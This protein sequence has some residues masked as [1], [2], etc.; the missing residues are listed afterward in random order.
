[1]DLAAVRMDFRYDRWF[2]TEANVGYETLILDVMTGD[3]TLF[4]RADM[5]EQA[6]R[7][8]QPVLDAWEKD[9][10]QPPVYRAGS[11][12]PDEAD[13]L[14]AREGRAWRPINGDGERAPS[15]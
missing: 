8:V 3:P 10:S 1:M 15:S 2:P 7:V 9:A 14:L 4:M 11:S 6:W 13:S 12:G 5:V